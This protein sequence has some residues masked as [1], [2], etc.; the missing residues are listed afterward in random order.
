MKFELTKGL[1]DN[2]FWR[3]VGEI[4]SPG[5]TCAMMAYDMTTSSIEHACHA[6]LTTLGMEIGAFAFTV[7]PHH[8]SIPFCDF[9]L[10]I[11]FK[12][13]QNMISFG[14][15]EVSSNLVQRFKM[16]GYHSGRKI[17][18]LFRIERLRWFTI[19]LNDN[20]FFFEKI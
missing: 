14:D 11:F 13:F 8:Y 20:F 3:K 19:W 6:S 4:M 1:V 7:V 16:D 18:L 5:A 15:C 9:F 12:Q 2:L 10:A 17:P